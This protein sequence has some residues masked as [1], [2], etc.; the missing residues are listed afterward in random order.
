MNR[1]LGGGAATRD[2]RDQALEVQ[3][4]SQ[5]QLQNVRTAAGRWQAGLAGLSGTITIFGL[6]KG[7]DDV[8]GLTAQWGIAYG[9]CLAAALG[10]SIGAG[11]LAMRAAFGLPRV[12]STSVV[13]PA[14]RADAT[15]A[16]RCA[17]LLHA[18]I[19]VTVASLVLVAVA[20]G[21]AWYAPKA[22]PADVVV[23]EISGAQDCGTVVRV[24]HDQLVLSTDTG[25]RTISLRGVDGL[26]GTSSCSA[27]GG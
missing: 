26:A 27:N 2:A 9:V 5:A 7:A 13:M 24:S 22:A 1:P 23:H 20:L 14:R 25:Q 15:E 10:C 3:A 4:A 8:N 21:V 12:V 17:G 19:W 18:A 11:V 16:R 6:V